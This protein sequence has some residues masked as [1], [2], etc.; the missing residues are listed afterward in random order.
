MALL[1]PCLSVSAV[2]GEQEIANLLAS[3]SIMNGYPDGELRLEQSVTRAEFSKIAI[4]ASP[5]KNQVAS[6]LSI[7][8][9]GD[10]S[11]KHWAAPYVK[12]AVSNS[13]VTGYPDSTFRPDQTVLLEEAVTVMLKLLGYTNDD[14]GYS[15]PYGQ[16]GLAENIGLLDDMSATVGTPMSRRDVMLLTYNLLTCSPKTV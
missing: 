9:F 15:W 5:Y 1:L 10:V 8:P 6:S 13:L 14:F 3:M 11:Y 12:L 2:A 16:L 7:S 4:A